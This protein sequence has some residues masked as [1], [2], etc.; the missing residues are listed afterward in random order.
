MLAD[1]GLVSQRSWE[2]GRPTLRHVAPTF[3]LRRP[4]RTR[5]EVGSM[6]AT[7]GALPAG[8]RSYRTDIDGLRALSILLVV[9]FHAGWELFG[10]GYVGV[11]VF[12]V[13]SGYL[14]TGLLIKE[15]RTKG[16]ISL[17]EFYARR[18]RRLLPL[19]AV[20]LVVTL[21]LGLWLL[22]P[23][24]RVELVNDARAAA[25][26]FANWRF[27]SQATAYSDAAVTDALLLHYWSLS[28]EEQFYFLWPL[29]VVA[30]GWW[31]RRKPWLRFDLVLGGFLAFLVMV[32]L[33]SSVL[34]TSRLGPGAYYATHTRLWEMGVGAGL[35]LVLPRLARPRPVAAEVMGVVGL[36][37]VVG[38]AMA[39]GT[40][41][42]FPG[43][44]A[45]APV[46][47]TVLILVAGSQRSTRIARVLSSGGLPTLGRWSY[48]WYLWHWPLIGV[49]R[50][51]T[52]R[53]NGAWSAQ[54][55]TL[56]AVVASLGLAALS[57][58]LVE[59]P[60]RYSSVL[61]R[62]Q[63]S[64]FVLGASLTLLPV[65][66]GLVFLLVGD[67]GNRTGTPVASDQGATDGTVTRVS[68]TPLDASKDEVSVGPSSCHADQAASEADLSCVFGDP[69]GS[70]TVVLIG[71][72]H[73]RHWL[74]ALEVIAQ[75]EGWR[76]LSVTKSG[77]NP[78]DVPSWN[79]N[80]ER[81]YHECDAWRDSLLEQLADEH[82]VALVIVGRALGHRA[83]VFI[84]GELVP[85]SEIG[86]VWRDGVERT[87][88]RLLEVSRRV[89]VLRDSPWA[90]EDVPTCL[91]EVWPEM[92]GC[93]F[94]VSEE[95]E[96]DS[97]LYE[98]ERSVAP[99][100]VSFVEVSDL[101]CPSDPCQMVAPNGVIKYRDR[102]HITQTFS[103]QLAPA[104]ADRIVGF[105]ADPVFGGL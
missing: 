58:R 16:R 40:T 38:A 73:A 33:G 67:I 60:I 28:V 80:Y 22:P 53:S 30:A 93:D 96:D 61:R 56:A 15:Y 24:S 97:E 45:L 47:G 62:R 48:A 2:P 74:P 29:L 34:L 43:A 1:E 90:P 41:T 3:D 94:A 21:A 32:S 68:M 105:G 55:A 36:G 103:R 91:S 51:L 6:A 81:P 64:N 65:I 39:Y 8:E 44:A 7:V 20:V 87:F 37:A 25:L 83:S 89:V 95:G 98:A 63:R 72:S 100:G 82:D 17:T 4:A 31:A 26:Y 85:R 27:A 75:D 102:H 84:E 92:T 42:D 86:P 35:A 19:A 78:F 14:I 66:G 76:L 18:I 54:T 59:N 77:C 101:V 104:L 11:D 69:E 52:D 23:L 5:P 13:L 79:S 46:V 10:G 88:E 70:P 50:L 9:A 49:A 71:D 99:D 57:H 12:F